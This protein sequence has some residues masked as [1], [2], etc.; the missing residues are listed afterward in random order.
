MSPVV[1]LIARAVL[2]GIGGF[3]TAY[4]ADSDLAR[5]LV[6]GLALG[7]GLAVA[8]LG[9]PLNATVGVGKGDQPS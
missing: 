1:R 4:L 2:V 6:N 7:A 3:C 5:A 8:E 9:T